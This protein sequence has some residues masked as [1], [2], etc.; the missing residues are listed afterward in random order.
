MFVFV[1]HFQTKCQPNHNFPS[2]QFSPKLLNHTPSLV[3]HVSVLWTWL[4]GPSILVVF[5]SCH[6]YT[7]L[8]RHS[9]DKILSNYANGNLI[10]L[11]SSFFK[12][13]DG[14]ISPTKF[15]LPCIITQKW[16]SDTMYKTGVKMV[17]STQLSKTTVLTDLLLDTLVVHLNKYWVVLSHQ[18]QESTKQKQRKAT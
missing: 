16:K 11:F 4:L 12:F 1:C 10:N 15:H 6:A 9:D 17:F 3:I 5:A 13:Q 18:S 8:I 2:S 14:P 7:G